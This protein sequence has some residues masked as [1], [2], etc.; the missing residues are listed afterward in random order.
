MKRY[1]SI[2]L[3]LALALSCVSFAAMA[4]VPELK[5]PGNVTL[6]RLGYNVAFDPN[7][8]GVAKLTEEV[9][10]YHVEYYML[11]AEQADEKLA[12]EVTGGADYDVVNLNYDQFQRLKNQGALMPLNDLLEAY[13]KDILGALSEET[14]RSMSDADL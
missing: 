9:T 8:D 2:L 11:P 14:W 3:A 7:T 6:K 10:G 13:G 1:L 12:M 5:G 4:D